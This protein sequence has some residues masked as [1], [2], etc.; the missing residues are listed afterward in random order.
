M[1]DTSSATQALAPPN[2]CSY[3]PPTPCPPAIRHPALGPMIPSN[4]AMTRVPLT[5]GHLVLHPGLCPTLPGDKR[6]TVLTVALP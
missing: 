5:P 4:C 3:P 2:I 1:T 6:E